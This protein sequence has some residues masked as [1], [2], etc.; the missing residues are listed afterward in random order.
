MYPQNDVTAAIRRVQQYLYEIHLHENIPYRS[1]PDGIYGST[2]KNSISDF[3]KRFNLPATGIVD[4]PTFE[5]LRTTAKKYREENNRDTQLYSSEGFPIQRG[6]Q[7][8]DVEVLHALLRSLAEFEK[9]FPPIPRTSYFSSETEKSVR[10][11]QS[12]FQLEE[13]GEIDAYL[14]D[15]MEEQLK[16]KQSMKNKNSQFD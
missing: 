9:D 6:D 5:A 4:L 7:G 13:N 3:Q 15:R 11:M 12:I 1:I 16:A 8:A 14:F 10:Y 2:T